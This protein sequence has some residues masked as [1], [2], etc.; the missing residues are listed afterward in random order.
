VII[1]TDVDTPPGTVRTLDDFEDFL[2]S[3]EGD[4]TA[5]VKPDEAVNADEAEAVIAPG[6]RFTDAGADFYTTIGGQRVPIRTVEAPDAPDSNTARSA[7]RAGDADADD[8]DTRTR[9]ETISMDEIEEISERVRPP[10][11][12]PAPAG[13][14]SPGP[15][16]GYSSGGIL[17]RTYRP[18]RSRYDG[19]A[20]SSPVVSDYGT[21]YST[22]SAAVGSGVGSSYSYD[23]FATGGSVGVSG[24]SNSPYGSGGSSG[25]FY[26]GGSS[27]GGG[28]SNDG[29]GTPVYDRIG[30]PGDGSGSGSTG[31]PGTPGSTTI[32][33]RSTDPGQPGIPDQP[34]K[35]ENDDNAANGFDAWQSSGG[36]TTAGD[37][38]LATGWFRETITT[39]ALGIDPEAAQAPSQSALED[40]PDDV[41]LAG[42]YPT[43]AELTG[44]D[45]QQAQIEAAEDL[46]TFGGDR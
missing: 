6:S 13:P 5:Y 35:P 38:S 12:R 3:Q 36:S 10:S 42:A 16:A 9:S 19:P 1:R 22:T 25:G 30:T 11:D 45:E 4:T 27:T 15:G 39:A 24:Y 7:G 43:A 44:T 14:S 40:Q 8:F 46:F 29:G 26:G 33:D 37:D 32:P 17:E 28:P 20:A 21:G 34:E 41:A 23:S 18:V 31:D 2:R